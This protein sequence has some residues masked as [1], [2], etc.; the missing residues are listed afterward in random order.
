MNTLTRR[1]VYTNVA[2]KGQTNDFTFIVPANC[3]IDSIIIINNNANAVTGGLKFGTTAGGTDVVSSVAVGA[4]AFTHV[5]DSALA[6]KVFSKTANTTIYVQ[7]VTAWNSAN[8]DVNVII[9]RL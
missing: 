5:A 3:F 9:G 4:N 6:K 7:D 8:V 2:S 1:R